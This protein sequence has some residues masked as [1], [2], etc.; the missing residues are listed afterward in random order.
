[1]GERIKRLRLERH[2]T[3]EELGNRFGLKRAAINK[4]EKGNVENMKRTIIEEMSNFFGVSPSY[5]MALDNISS[6]IE[7]IYNQLV[8]V[9]QEKVYVF[10][11]N[12]LEEQDKESKQDE[13][14][15]SLEQF[16]KKKEEKQELG[17]IRYCG[18]V[19]AGTGE[20][21][22]DN[23][24][25]DNIELPVEQIP[26]EADFCLKVNGDS[27][28]PIFHD[29]DYVFIKKQLEIYNGN[30]GVVIVNGESFL[31]RIWFVNN[32]IRL[33]SFNKKYQD[34]IITEDDEFQIIGRVVM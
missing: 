30:I 1:M 23:Q 17:S 20:F 26:D 32:N 29:K 21:L 34:I 24:P 5:L 2:L 22:L 7:K 15:T 18:S 33:Q 6:P 14:I 28:E 13:N 19:S 11:K 10:A 4:Y 8:P 3:Q 25:H 9:R 16:R 27:M 31:K 12:Q